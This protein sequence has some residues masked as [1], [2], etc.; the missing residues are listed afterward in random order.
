MRKNDTVALPLE[1][2]VELSRHLEAMYKGTSEM[3]GM[4]VYNFLC[5]KHGEECNIAVPK[6]DD[7]QI[8]IM[9]HQ[10]QIKS[11]NS[12]ELVLR[13]LGKNAGKK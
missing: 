7:G 10:F 9:Q 4:G 11:D 5:Y 6:R 12:G 13:Y 8:T 3:G 2:V 1:K